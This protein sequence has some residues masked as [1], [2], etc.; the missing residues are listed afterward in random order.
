MCSYTLFFIHFLH[1]RQN[2][3]RPKIMDLIREFLCYKIYFLD[4]RS[5]CCY[6]YIRNSNTSNKST[7]FVNPTFVMDTK[8]G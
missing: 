5:R 4:G 7:R 2:D 6:I 8:L 3:Y 1:I